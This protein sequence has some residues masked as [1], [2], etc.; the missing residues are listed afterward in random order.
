MH[1]LPGYRVGG[2]IHIIANNQLGFTGDANE[3]RSTLYASDLAKGFKIPIV[4]VNADDVEACIEV[5]RLAI[6]YRQKFQ[7][8]FLI[9]LI[10]YRRYGHNEGDE[11]RFTQPQMYAR[12]DQHPT[13]RQQWATTLQERGEVTQPEAEGFQEKFQTKLQTLY[14][15]MEVEEVADLLEPQLDPPPPGAARKAVTAVSLERLTQ[16]NQALY[17]LPD[18]FLPDKK[19]ARLLQR[20]EKALATPDEN[21]LDWAAAEAL[22]LASILAEGTSIRLTGE[23]VERG[24]FSHR[25]AVLH[26][27]ETGV[28]H[29]LFQELSEA[30]AAF[31]IRNSPLTENGVIGFEYGYN[32]QAPERLVVWEAQYGD[33]INTAQ[34]I[35]DEFVVSGKAKWEQTPSLVLLLP[36]GYEGQGPDHSSGR[37]ERFLQ[38]AAKTSI[39][40]AYPTTAAQ[41]FHLL[42][43]QTAVLQED[44]LPLVVMTPKSLLRHPRAASSPRQLAEEEWWR[45]IPDQQAHQRNEEVRRLVL[46]SGKVFVDLI[47][48]QERL[49]VEEDKLPVA[50]TRVEQLYPFPEAAVIEELNRYPNL[51]EVVWVQEEPANMGAWEFV[52]P[53]LQNLCDGRMPLRYIGRPR[54]SSPAEGS[55]SWHRSNQKAITEHAFKFSE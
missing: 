19:L 17:S 51:E 42:R 11:P 29:C 9:D 6:A 35:I 31:E 22:A 38:L 41:Y 43:R 39:R 15:S 44:P 55:T 47:E 16:L 21:T 49:L 10:G 53:L 26:H 8:D 52:R 12:I 33:F 24:T 37:L 23:D 32:I 46:C 36:H 20:R 50:L 1:Q 4:H 13:V 14:E 54:R 3:S 27:R 40:I 7:K 28:E 2:T 48:I 45:V 30:K 5:A 18:G 34:A 25:H